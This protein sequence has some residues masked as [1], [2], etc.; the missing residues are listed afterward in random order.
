MRDLSVELVFERGSLYR[1]LF[2][3]AEGGGCGRILCSGG[4]FVS[5]SCQFESPYS[6]GN[7]TV[8]TFMEFINLL[9]QLSFCDK[10]IAGVT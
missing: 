1:G 10:V 5:I 2:V 4:S 3:R 6:H 7:T 8:E 9:S